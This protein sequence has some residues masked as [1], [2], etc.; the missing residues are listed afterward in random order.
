[1]D[2]LTNDKPQGE[3]AG[4][5]LLDTTYPFVTK[6]IKLRQDHVRLAGNG[7]VYFTYI[8]SPGAVGVVPVTRDGNMVLI[9]QYRYTVDEWCIE[10]PAGGMHDSNGASLEQVAREEL[11][12]EVGGTCNDLIYVNCFYT[13]VGNSSQAFRVFLALDVDLNEPIA[14]EPTEQ[15]ELYPLPVAEAL[16][17]AHS[18]EMKDGA[19]A[20]SVL[21]C[22]DLLREHG[23]L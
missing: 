20:M 13:A 4:W 3:K 7:E 14:R 23:Y 6:W 18:G 2:S 10:I 11:R 12:Q 16:R 19:S 21:L 17:L 15:I 1:V 5:H 9:R 8:D 22:E